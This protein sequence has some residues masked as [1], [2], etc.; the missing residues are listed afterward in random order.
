MTH[1]ALIRTYRPFPPLHVWHIRYHRKLY[2]YR[3]RCRLCR[4]SSAYIPSQS[5]PNII[6]W[7]EALSNALDH[8]HTVHG[9]SSMRA[10]GEPCD[11]YCADCGGKGWIK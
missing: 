5:W 6:T 9:C 8:L 3:W 7:C 4:A 10:S 2:G 11:E 1:N